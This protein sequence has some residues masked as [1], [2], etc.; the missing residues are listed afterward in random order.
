MKVRL[1]LPT[2]L[3]IL[4]TAILPAAP[5]QP[6]RYPLTVVDDAGNAVTLAAAPGRIVSQTLATDEILL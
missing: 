6:T 2:V 5:R 4:I 1:I 3:G